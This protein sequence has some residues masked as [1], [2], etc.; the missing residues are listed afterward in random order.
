[1]ARLRGETLTDL[2][3]RVL[4]RRLAADR[5]DPAASMIGAS[6][7]T[8]WED[9][10]AAG[11]CVAATPSGDAFAP[12]LARL[13]AETDRMAAAPPSEPELDAA[14]KEARSYLRG[15]A[16]QAAT[17]PSPELATHA[18]ELM[19]R[20]DVVPSPAEAFRAFDSA[21]A[22]VTPEDLRAAFRRDWAGSGPRIVV[23][24]ATAATGPA[25]LAAWNAP[26]APPAVTEASRPAETWAYNDFG[27]AGKVVRREVFPGADYVRL[28]FANGVTL[29]FKHT[30]FEQNQVKVAMAFGAGRRE[31]ADADDVAAQI[32]AV[33][34]KQG[35]L[36]RH[37]IAAIDA[38]FADRGW[39]ADL[40][41]GP[42][43]FVLEGGGG[44]SALE[45]QLQILAAFATDP[46]FRDIDPLISTVVAAVYSKTRADPR[47][48]LGQAL[49]EGVAP[50]GPESLPPREVL[51]RLRTADL[52]RIF[53]PP[54]T[55]APLRLTIVGDVS[56]AQAVSF[57]AE[58]LGALPARP[59][60][61]RE[62]AG[63]SFLRFPTVMPGPIEATHDG[64]PERALT[65][66]VW[67]LYVATPARRREEYALGLTAALL[68]E[69]LVGRLRGDLGKT[70]SPA[71]ATSM[72][73]EADQ[74][75]LEALVETAPGDVDLA[76]REIEASAARLAQ[77]DVTS[78]Q[79]EAVRA[80][81]V[82]RIAQAERTNGYWL[83]ALANAA[84]DDDLAAVDAADW[85]SA[86]AS[87]TLE[88]V[89]KA[90]AVWLSRP[91]IIVVV[92]PK[93][94]AGPG[95]SP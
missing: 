5:R 25:I 31:I 71:A 63:V 93:P 10:D 67:P 16:D 48:A 92:R 17:R 32:G 26:S 51:A 46:G 2:W 3:R 76:R 82:A 61:A 80:P 84:G 65:A 1:M 11:A 28:T 43:A 52:R 89:R 35:G 88:E 64:P 94:S 78:A 72:P 86:E 12:A 21:V 36:G 13:R 55:Q 30:S 19:L 37:D 60:A 44:V 15:P 49:T 38:L 7:I 47:L 58:T 22:D 34:I 74:G 81:L 77:G 50:G 83:D 57:T 42:H 59:P 18:V 69:R 79:L 27:P 33:L 95:A 29:N 54:L 62:K 45:G 91:P 56:E 73:D 23:V 20:G 8:A 70:Y 6:V 41:I 85:R 40:H 24:G 87:I 66:A 39:G 9:R 4:D 75:L 68:Q 14:L 53:R 90:A